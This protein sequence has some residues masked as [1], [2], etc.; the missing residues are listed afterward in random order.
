MTT[1][2]TMLAYRAAFSPHHHHRRRAAPPINTLACHNTRPNH[3]T[4]TAKRRR[5]TPSTHSTHSH[6]SLICTTKTRSPSLNS[7]ATCPNLC[8]ATHRLN[9][10]QCRTKHARVSAHNDH[11]RR[12]KPNQLRHFP[13]RL[14]LT[15]DL[16]LLEFLCSTCC[17]KQLSH[18]FLCLFWFCFVFSHKQ[19]IYS[20]QV[21][22]VSQMSNE[23]VDTVMDS[24]REIQP[25]HPPE[26]F[27][28][29]SL[30]AQ[31]PPKTKPAS[32]YGKIPSFPEDQQ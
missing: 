22:N 21:P 29:E 30:F 31:V 8:L 2:A 1:R 9:H 32:N 27:S 23:D 18:R 11:C 24:L 14:S 13:P 17:F 28:S 6:R 5:Q 4:T 19:F 10:C 16:C 25:E 12:C 26:M 15:L 20:D 7:P 3:R